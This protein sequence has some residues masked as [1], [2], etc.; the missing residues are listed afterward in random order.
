MLWQKCKLRK[1]QREEDLPP[2]VAGGTWLLGHMPALAGPDRYTVLDSWHQEFGPTFRVQLPL[3][4]RCGM[5]GLQRAN[6]TVVMSKADQLAVMSAAGGPFEHRTTTDVI[7]GKIMFSGLT[8][9]WHHGGRD[10]MER[11]KELSRAMAPKSLRTR[12]PTLL[13]CAR[14]FCHRIRES[15][16]VALDKEMVRIMVDMF[17]QAEMTEYY[18]GAVNRDGPGEA[19]M[20]DM[21]ICLEFALKASRKGFFPGSRLLHYF[22]AHFTREGREASKARSRFYDAAALVLRHHEEKVES[23]DYDRD[24]DGTNVAEACA[25]LARQGKPREDCISDLVNYLF[26][27]HDTG[28]GMAFCLHALAARPDLQA[29]LR[30]ELENALESCG[31]EKTL[32]GLSSAEDR[33]FLSADSRLPLFNAVLK[34]S[35]RLWP[36]PLWPGT[37]PL[38]PTGGL[39]WRTCGHDASLGGFQVP[40]G[41]LACAPF[42]LA[43]RDIRTWGDDAAEFRPERWLEA[44][45]PEAAFTPFSNGVR[46]CPGQNLASTA[47][48]II[49][50]SCLLGLEGS[51]AAGSR[52]TSILALYEGGLACT[53]SPRP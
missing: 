17:A 1:E 5:F 28:F 32:D 51:Q 18:M 50:A 49:L 27:S 10:H 15:T 22:H 9:G 6:A 3:W 12:L 42:Y 7:F 53:F 14:T 13:A 34:E 24:R 39:T 36:A 21:D 45:I 31:C 48:R 30:K 33:L 44:R 38:L 2:L 47:S 52:A 20:R 26:S 16:E 40:R 25:N 41:W 43:Q 35:L 46:G 8:M 37:C 4:H 23:G 19:F 11:K 29:A